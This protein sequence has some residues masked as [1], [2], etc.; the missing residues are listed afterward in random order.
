MTRILTVT[1]LFML[2]ATAAP[3]QP[4]GGTLARVAESGRFLIGYAPNAMPMSFRDEN[5]TPVGYSIELCKV[6]ANAVKRRLGLDDMAVEYVPLATMTERIN[7][8]AGGKVDIECGASTI[9]LGRRER[10]DFT[11]MTLI[12]GA[13]SLSL[14]TAIVNTNA[15]L[16]GRK[17][18]V[19]TDTTTEAALQFFLET[20]EFEAEVIAVDSHEEAL[21]MLNEGKVDA[22]VSDQIILTGQVIKAENPRDYHLAPDVFSYEP[23]GF[24]IRKGDAEFRLVADEALARFYRT[25]RIQRLYHDWFGRFG[26]RQSRVLSAMYQFQGL[27]D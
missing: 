14:T 27:P 19:V 21:A 5:G 22:H 9:T 16:D 20:N 8:V 10:V 11:L 12:T 6:I 2:L 7:A 17:L 25:A 3:A 26:I 1:S 24:M 15:D 13:S 18:V 23:Y 4:A